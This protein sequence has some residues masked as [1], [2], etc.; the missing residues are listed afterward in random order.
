M[1]E[2]SCPKCG[3]QVATL[4]GGTPRVTGGGPARMETPGAG[5]PMDHARCEKGHNLSRATGQSEW[6]FVDGRPAKK[7]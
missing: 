5:P 3:A 7:A 1:S 2:P 4:P 6:Q